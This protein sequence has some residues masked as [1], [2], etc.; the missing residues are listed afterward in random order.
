MPVGP[1]AVDPTTG[2]L[3]LSATDVSLAGAGGV[4]RV[5][6]SRNTSGGAAGPLGPQWALSL[7]GGEGM[8]VLPT[9]SVVLSSSGGGTTTFRRNEKGELESPLGDEN[10]KVEAKEKESG[11]GISEYLL[12]DAH[13]DTATVF[14][15]PV[16][17]ETTMPVYANQFG[18]EGSEL[19]HAV[20]T[21]TDA[22]G[23]VWVTDYSDGRILEFSTAGVLIKSYGSE[24]P[25]MGNFKDP[26]GIAVNKSTGNVYVSDPGNNR[27]VEMSP[28]GGFVRAFGWG[29]SPGATRKNEFQDCTEYCEAGIVGS[30]AG[31]FNWPVGVAIDS[32]GNVWVAEANNQRIQK[33]NAEG[34]YLSTYGSTGTGGGQFNGPLNIAFVG[35]NLF[36]TD[37]LNNRVQELTGTGAFVKAI[38]WGV[39]NGEEKLQVCTSG[40]RAGIA[41]SGKGQFYSPIGLAAD[42]TGDLYVVDGHDNRVQELTSEGSYLTQFGATGSGTGQLLE[43]YGVAVGPQG[44]IYVAEYANKRIQEWMRPSWLP[45]RT[46]GALKNVTTAYSYKPVEEEGKVVIEPAEALAATPAGI[47]CVGAK[48]EVEVQYLKNGCRALTFTYANKTKENIGENRNGWGEYTGR[49]SQVVFHGYNPSGKTMEAKPVAEYAYDKQGRLRAEWD[50][51]ISP[52]LK[53]NYGYDPEGHVTAVTPPGQES[54]GTVYG[55]IAGD[56]NT[57]RLLKVTRAPASAKLW[58]GEA[59]VKAESPKLSGTPAAGVRMSVSN[60]VWSG[61]PVVYGYQWEDCNS[62]G[63]EC[64]AILGATN[65]NYTPVSGDV[66]HTLVAQVT[67]VNGGGSVL[68]STAASA[69]V[70]AK[71]GSHTQTVDNGYSLNAVSCISG[72]TTCVLSDSAGKALYA[73]NVSSSSAATWSSWSGPGTSP[74]E[75]VACPASSLCLVAA[76]KNEGS[77]GNLYYATSLGGAWS[78]AYSPSYGVD[79][80]SCA[81]TSFC[82]DGQDGLG[83]F[84]WSTSPGSTSWNLQQQGTA[85]MK[86]I[87]CLSA[88]F[89]A[90][91]DSAGNVHVA[92]TESQVKSSSWTQTAV[93]GSTTL[94]GIACLSTSSCVAVDNSG[95]ELTLKIESN[96]TATATKHNIDGTTSLASVAC[97]G[98]SKCVA[99]DTAGHVFVSTNSGETWTSLYSLGVNLTGV[100]CDSTSLCAAPDTTGK[101]TSF[102]LTGTGTEGE[103]HTP[104]PGSTIE[105]RIPVSGGGVPQNLSKEEVEKWGQTKDYPAEG[106]A[107]FPPD[108]PQGWPSSGYKRATIDYMDEQGRTV[109]TVSPSGAVTTSEYNEANEITRTLTPANRAAAM[110]EGCISVVKKECKSAE[111][112][113]KL[114][115]RTE[116]NEEGSQIL[117]V[118]GPEHKTEL[119]SGTEVQARAVT[120]NYYNEGAEEA[121]EKNKE[122]YNLLTRSTAGALLSNGEEKDVRTNRTYYSGQNDLGW[123]LR[124]PTSTVTDPAGLDLT[125]TTLYNKETGAVIEQRAPGGTAETVYPPFYSFSIGSEGSERG[126]FNHPESDAIDANGNLWVVDKVNDRIEEFSGSGTLIGAYGEKG[127]GKLQF[128]EPWGIANSPKTGNVFVGDAGNNRVEVLNSKGEYVRSLESLGTGHGTFNKPSGVIVDAKGN[129]WVSD[130]GNNRVL[131][132]TETGEYE[133]QIGN[134]GSGPGELKGP[135]DIAISEGEVYVADSGNNRVAEF[136]PDGSYLGQIGTV[137]KGPGQ[138]SEPHGIAANPTNGDLYITDFNEERVQE[139][140]PAGKFLTQW[141][142]WS[143]VH[144]V[145]NPVGIAINSSGRLYIADRYAGKITAWSLPEAGGAQ[146]NYASAFGTLGSGE[147]QFNRPYSAAIDGQGNLW[148]TDRS[149]N[150]IE[151]LTTQGKMLASYGTTGTGELQ[152]K[153]PWGIAINKSTGNAYIADGENNRIEELSSTG[154]FVRTFGTSGS[155]A[156]ELPKGIAIDS[157]GNVWV[158]DFGHNRIVEFSATGE[159]I[160]AYGSYGS[161]EKQF[162]SP[163]DLV[164]SAGDIYVSDVGDDRIEELSTSGAYVRS[165]GLEGSGSG[166]F[167]GPFGI[168]ADAAGNVYVVDQGNDRVEEFSPTGSFLASFGSKG[169]GEGQLSEPTSLT[170]SSSG[171]LYVMDTANNRVEHWTPANRAAHD[172]KTVYYTAKEEAE[173]AACRNHPEW[174]GLQCVVEPAEQ[175][176]GS[177]PSLPVVTFTAYNLLDELETT[178]EVFG[179]V[180]RT[181]TQTYDAAGRAMTSEETSTVDTALPKVTNEYNTETGVLEKQSATIKSETKTSTSKDNKLGQL[182]EYT[183]ATGNIA[184]YTYEEGGDG[185]LLEV[186]EGKGEEAKSSQTY[187]YDPTTGFMTKLVDSAAG[188]FTAGYDLEG[189]M[190]SEVYPNGM[191][192][193]TSYDSTGAATNITYI[194]T[195]NCSESNPAIWFKDSI[196]FGIHGETLAQTSTLA[197]ENYSYDSIGRLTETQE[198]PSG[199]GC[200]TR[201]YAYDEESN[202]TNLTTRVPGFEGKCA[203]EGGTIQ[204]HTYDPAS[205]LTDEGVEYEALGNTTKLPATDAGEH[206]IKSTYYIDN[207]VATQEQ[208]KTLDSYVYDPAGRAMEMTSENSETKA[209]T[210]TVSHY[211]GTGEAATWTSEGSEKWTRNIPGIDGSLCATQ[212]STSE[213]VLQLHDLQGNIVAT[214]SLSESATELISNT[215]APSSVRP[216]KEKPRPSSPGSAPAALP[217]KRRSEPG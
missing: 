51:R 25:Y 112:A 121:E 74:S 144:E 81:S 204:H 134:S 97:P 85:A 198:T 191:C 150:R 216:M 130:E 142:T 68:A 205:R 95:N 109:N 152:F 179:S 200:A 3:K 56:T 8:T 167:Y 127:A 135:V 45:A 90:I 49:L 104:Q 30:G 177:L 209:K 172:T 32:S 213:P 126:Q 33:F 128:S 117:K 161:G 162:K 12:T 210:T 11:K 91:A 75:A 139:F 10:I 182:I 103:A 166:E 165:F 71:A 119:S 193:N 100:S 143:K 211:S 93:D 108:E 155:G 42:S 20:G 65:A 164:Y 160:A 105:Y 62:E 40:C 38:G 55:T 132:L 110:A 14:T 107:I 99:V 92:T 158:A 82:A 50:P 111:T 184:K 199:K 27:V 190:T 146:L 131:E 118:L 36:V 72:T 133:N 212:T 2:Q 34:K 148:V 66:G 202:R 58:S 124:K 201:L 141:G 7:G 195:R 64:V 101:V 80:I 176:G 217:P 77:G 171:D 151:K 115:T 123:T 47:T 52:A 6:E 136:A 69:V 181:K 23:N 106:T 17:T 46:E 87:S 120:H 175:P 185:R 187:S 180:T 28:S 206:E 122:E 163:A 79:A 125:S 59:P 61:E 31:Q 153:G 19:G 67:A 196:V 9:G 48:G 116:Y 197:N 57:G 78:L 170:I 129:L 41:G 5:Y 192:A 18:Q 43:P 96:G 102:N 39:S 37:E 26:W 113:E 44:Q 22:S 157:S 203:T 154:T 215:T 83:Y 114:D 173:I 89:C 183:D 207:Q 21:A 88:S 168:T 76:G 145:G 4:S 208:N 169:S 24:G 86:A 54:W 84:R 35:S 94:D 138:F 159:Y 73:T 214:A 70:V 156:L 140:S 98:S 13:A 63:K 147:G 29:V 16:G 15:Q 149:N 189:K 137:G 60:G 174:A 186:K 194:K 1:G 53:M 178:S 188:T